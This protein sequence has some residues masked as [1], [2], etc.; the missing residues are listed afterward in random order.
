LQIDPLEN[1]AATNLGVIEAQAGNLEQA[2]RLWEEAFYRAPDNMAIGLSLSEVLWQEGKQAQARE[3]L[4]RML[5][6]NPDFPE[7]ENLLRE[8][9]R[10]SSDSV[11]H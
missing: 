2:R 1:A 4:T 9:S 7:A 8:W 3:E 10:D 11:R 6:F 5:E